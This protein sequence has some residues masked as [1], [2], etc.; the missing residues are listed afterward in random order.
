MT[1]MG[2]KTC[3]TWQNKGK[4]I[5]LVFIE[6]QSRIQRLTGGGALTHSS[7]GLAGVRVP[8]CCRVD[9]DL[10]TVLGPGLQIGENQSVLLHVADVF[11]LRREQRGRQRM[12]GTRVRQRN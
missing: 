7:A 1:A 9:L 10:D 4:F 2:F 12:C 11:G 8:V 6:L 3:I 5:H